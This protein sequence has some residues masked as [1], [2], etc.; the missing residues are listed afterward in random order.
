MEAVPFASKYILIG[1][2]YSMTCSKEKAALCRFCHPNQLL[3]RSV[4]RDGNRDAELKFD[5][6]PK[7]GEHFR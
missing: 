7:P 4:Q 1:T 3:S 6:S 2:I 5:F